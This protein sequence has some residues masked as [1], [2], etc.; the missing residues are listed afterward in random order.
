MTAV[1]LRTHERVQNGFT[2]SGPGERLGGRPDQGGDTSALV[3]SGDCLRALPLQLQ[4]RLARGNLSIRPAA[5]P[6]PG[7]RWYMGLHVN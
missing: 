1:L 4:R 3:H 5:E 7:W 6:L 2:D